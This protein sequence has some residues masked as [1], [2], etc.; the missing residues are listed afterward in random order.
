M[1]EE[2]HEGI[3]MARKR[4][5]RRP[6]RLRIVHRQDHAAARPVIT[7][8]RTTNEP[9]DVPLCTA[10]SNADV[11]RA[12]ELARTLGWNALIAS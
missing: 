6:A 7:A 4:N 11:E 10:V 5:A 12:R 8:F 2:R 1:P 3:V 9:D